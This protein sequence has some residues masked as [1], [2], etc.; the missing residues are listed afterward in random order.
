MDFVPHPL[1]GVGQNPLLLSTH[2]FNV[3]DNMKLDWI[4]SNQGLNNK[5]AYSKIQ[6]PVEFFY[7]LLFKIIFY[8]H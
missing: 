2:V 4:P 3:T 7:L 8:I 1:V 5:N 6:L